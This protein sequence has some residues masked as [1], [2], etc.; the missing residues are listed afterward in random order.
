[1]SLLTGMREGNARA[2]LS[3][4]LEDPEVVCPHLTPFPSSTA[5]VAMQDSRF[6]LFIRIRGVSVPSKTSYLRHQERQDQKKPLL[7]R[8]F[9]QENSETERVVWLTRDCACCQAS[10]D[11]WCRISRRCVHLRTGTPCS[12]TGKRRPEARVERGKR[13]ER[14]AL[15]PQTLVDRPSGREER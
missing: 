4:E 6:Q 14:H 7:Q 9:I 13:V 1:M 3:L 15:S 2:A 5:R 8:P 12:Q 11:P 10:V